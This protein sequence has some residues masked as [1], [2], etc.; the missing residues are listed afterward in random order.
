M[1]TGAAQGSHFEEFVKSQRS[2]ARYDN[3]SELV[4]AGLLMLEDQ[5]GCDAV[6]PGLLPERAPIDIG[7]ACG[8]R[9]RHGEGMPMKVF[10]VRRHTAIMHSSQL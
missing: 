8:M 2:S 6:L 10:F 4:C 7:L 9:D 5:K 3:V 1:P